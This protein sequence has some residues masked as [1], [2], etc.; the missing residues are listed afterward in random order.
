LS[1]IDAGIDNPA[2]FLALSSCLQKIGRRI[3]DIHTVLLTHG[4]P[5]H[6][7]G[8]NRIL[9]TAAPRI[10]IPENSIPEAVDL[11]KQDFYCLPP[12]VRE[13][14]ACMREFDILENF[15]RTCGSWLLSRSALT[16]IHDGQEIKLGRYVFRGIHT[17]GHDV[18]LMCFYEPEQKILVSGDLLRSS[19]PGSALP[20]YTSTAGGVEAYLASLERIEELVVQTLLPA[21]GA[22]TGAFEEMVQKTKDV[23]LERETTILSLLSDGPKT[24]EQL[25]GHLYRPIVLEICPWYS[26]V[27]E[28]HLS[29]LEKAGRVKRNGFEYSLA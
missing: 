10:L 2:C 20:W 28:S 18:G 13:I 6:V 7:G 14:S 3:E 22:P 25:D 24:C 4:H 16:G 17:P 8:T 29:A 5:D 1:L 15:S 23:I 19:G 11:A 21:H 9:Q 12:Q 26:T 27:T